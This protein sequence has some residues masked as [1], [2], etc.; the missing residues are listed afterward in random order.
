MKIKYLLVFYYTILI[1]LVWRHSVSISARC[2]SERN[3]VTTALPPQLTL[4][5]LPTFHCG[6]WDLLRESLTLCLIHNLFSRI[7]S[8]VNVS[9][10]FQNF[11]WSLSKNGIYEVST[12]WCVQLIAWCSSGIISMRLT[13]WAMWR[14]TTN[15]CSVW[16]DLSLDLKENNASTVSC[17]S[18]HRYHKA[19]MFNHLSIY[20]SLWT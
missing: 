11:I 5:L 9:R 3:Q 16:G 20:Q 13:V 10:S 8:S 4:G 18:N 2:L 14:W 12:I 15:L 1:T 17:N 19:N 6:K 7:Q